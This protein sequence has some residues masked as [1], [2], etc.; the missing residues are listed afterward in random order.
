MESTYQACLDG[1]MT[2][3][4]AVKDEPVACAITYISQK[5]YRV[6]EL[7]VIAGSDAKGWLP[8]E[9]EISKYARDMNCDLIEGYGRKGWQRL[10]KDYRPVYV[11]YRKEL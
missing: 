10:V 4:V 9:S 6:C 11:T 8:L 7:F 1:Q 5:L 3:W 2:L